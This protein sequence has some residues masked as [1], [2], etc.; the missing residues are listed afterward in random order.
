[1]SGL[2]SF[3]AEL[4]RRRVFRVLVVYTVVAWALIQVGNIVFPALRLPSW[5]ITLL[6]VLVV[7]GFPVAAVLAWGFD[8]TPEGVVRTPGP[9]RQEGLPPPGESRPETPVA[10]PT[11]GIRLAQ[12]TEGDGI[13]VLPFENLGAN[14]DDVYFSDGVTED[15]ITH[16]YRI[17]RLRVI[18]RTSAWQYKGTRL[19]ARQIASELGVAYLLEGS[20]RRSGDRVR[21]TAQLIDGRTDGHLWAETYD[22]VI[23]D[24]FEIQSEVASHIAA[25]LHLTLS[26]TPGRA[27]VRPDPAKASPRSGQGEGV[28]PGLGDAMTLNLE[29]YDLYL[30]GRHQWYRRSPAALLE[31]VAHLSA[32]IELDPGFVRARSALAETYVTLAIYGLRAADDVLPKARDEATAALQRDPAEAPALSA[33]A[34]VRAIYDWDWDRATVDFTKAMEAWPQY[35]VAPHWLAM[36]VYVP[37][38]RFD[39]AVRQLELARSRDP[40][41]PSIQASLGVVDFMR[42]DYVRS[43][44]HFERL[45][46]E[47]PGLQLAHLFLGLSL[48]HGGDPARAVD[49]LERAMEVGGWSPDV[50]AALGSALVAAG[51]DVRGLEALER[52]GR[53]ATDRYVS[54]VLMAV[55]ET[56]LSDHPAALRSLEQAL[57]HRA[58]DLIWIDVHPAFDALRHLPRF[59]NARG[60]IFG[61]APGG[62]QV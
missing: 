41:S 30:R 4:R 32:A 13:A 16:L 18:S 47:D 43:R 34:C 9:E 28:P 59:Q 54:P 12:P 11:R 38:G 20:V 42:R 40:L 5:S 19:G 35:A 15:L 29:A 14:A 44:Q 2:S 61:S 24:I 46:R 7:F 62:R 52:M 49:A 8:L 17:G 37:R 1:V 56:A 45:I 27:P 25:A 58:A 31:S 53:E 60:R 39:D 33:L 23:Q 6:V 21:I 3:I 26:G 10:D 57:D 51:Q 50:A 55:I 36:H 48:H 22:R